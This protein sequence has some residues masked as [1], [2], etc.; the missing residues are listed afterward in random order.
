MILIRMSGITRQL[1]FIYPKGSNLSS[2]QVL[3]LVGEV[4]TVDAGDAKSDDSG[5]QQ[6]AA[7]GD[8]NQQPAAAAGMLPRQHLRN[9]ARLPPLLRRRRWRSARRL[10]K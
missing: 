9:G 8:A 3:S 7:G 10:I 2:D 1:K 5:N 6:Q 4:L